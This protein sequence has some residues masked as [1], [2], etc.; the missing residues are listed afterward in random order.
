MKIRNRIVIF[1]ILQELFFCVQAEAQRKPS[2]SSSFPSRETEGYVSAGFQLNAMNYFGDIPS[3]VSFT[4]PG[5]GVFVMRKISPRSHLRLSLNWGR[6][7]GDDFSS[8]ENSGTYARNLHFRNDI[9]ELTLVNTWDLIGSYGKYRKRVPFTPF[10]F[11]GFGLIH[12]NPQA[13]IILNQSTEWVDLQPLGTE[14]QG[15]PG[16]DAPYS[17]IQLVLPLGVGFK[18]SVNER[19]DIA[20]E[21]GIRFTFFDHL[22]DVSGEYPNLDDLGNPLAASLSNR[23]L[24]SV[25]ARTNSTRNLEQAIAQFGVDAYIGFDG[26]R[27]ETLGSFRRG[28][29]TRGNPSSHD[30]YFTTGIHFSYIINV[31]L[32]CPQFGW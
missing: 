11:F 29:S 18:W 24:E 23:T 17:K 12:H 30:L 14:G 32:K 19:L 6:L 5:A 1:L 25:S 15:R 16:Y 9:V 8:A 4:R 3:G 22:D 21:S 28:E 13:K 26:I 27:Y 10:L 7:E 2:R 20:I 31:G